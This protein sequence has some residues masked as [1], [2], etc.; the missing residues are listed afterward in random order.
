VYEHAAVSALILTYN[1]ALNIHAA[2]ESLSPWCGDIHVVDSGSADCTRDIAA[3]FTSHVHV[4][5]Y[6]DHST[7]I[8]WALTNLQFANEW[9]LL[10][11]ADFVISKHLR[12]QIQAAV[13]NAPAKVAGFFVVHRYVFRGKEIRFGGTKKWWLRLVR[14]SRTSV[15]G[16]ELVDFRL[17]VDGETRKLTGILYEDNK[18]EY[19]I[20]FW[21]EKHQKF[22]TRMAW[23]EF[24]RRK[25]TLSWRYR[26]RLMGDP[27]QRIVWFKERW[28]RLPLYVRPFLY[29]GY[30]YILRL[31]ILDGWNGFLFHFLQGFWFRL[32]V[33]V[34]IGDC[35]RQLRVAG[36]TE[37]DLVDR[38]GR[39]EHMSPES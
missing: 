11:D 17:A 18:N 12:H 3:K 24:L 31:G 22:S 7:Q 2:I 10:V 35:A 5:A 14:H 1:E 28:Y 9:V 15:D 26:P 20:S 38:A 25:G 37:R 4:H 32:I 36:M 21:I 23:E 30:R 19:D 33:D 6:I 29:F 27:D 39:F 34:K 13:R 16:S 8:H